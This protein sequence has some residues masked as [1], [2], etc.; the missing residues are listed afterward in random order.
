MILN[1]YSMHNRNFLIQLLVCGV[2]GIRGLLVAKHAVVACRSGHGRLIY[3]K[4]MVGQLALDF[5]QNN[6]TA[7]QEPVQQVIIVNFRP[8]LITNNFTD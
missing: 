7:I 1:H 3:M 5:P 6:K 2:H 4:K 8:M